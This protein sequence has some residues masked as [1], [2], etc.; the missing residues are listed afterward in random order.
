MRKRQIEAGRYGPKHG[1]AKVTVRG[2]HTCGAIEWTSSRAILG[3]VET[4]DVPV[5][6]YPREGR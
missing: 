2:S 5:S 6:T 4:Y 1:R 3:A